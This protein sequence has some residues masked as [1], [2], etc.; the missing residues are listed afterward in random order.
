MGTGPAWAWAGGLWADPPGGGSGA[1]HPGTA[2]PSQNPSKFLE[3]KMADIVWVSVGLVLWAIAFLFALLVV[4]IFRQIRINEARRE[5][6]LLRLDREFQ[7]QP[8]G[9]LKQRY[10]AIVAKNSNP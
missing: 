7:N 9:N 10:L 8:G 3:L 4:A 6:D 5:L 2:F 1:Y